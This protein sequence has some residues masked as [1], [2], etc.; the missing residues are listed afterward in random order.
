MVWF[1]LYSP[2]TKR[3]R[4]RYKLYLCVLAK[5]TGCLVDSNCSSQNLNKKRLKN[6]KCTP[7]KA[8]NNSQRKTQILVARRRLSDT[9]SLLIDDIPKRFWDVQLTEPLRAGRYPLGWGPPL[10]EVSVAPNPNGKRSDPRKRERSVYFAICSRI[11]DSD[12][13]KNMKMNSA[14][15]YQIPLIPVLSSCRQNL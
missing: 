1:I 9:E 15:V 10:R 4:S 2:K 6:R 11:S 5:Y 3:W 8:T 13:C 12:T 7:K 14:I